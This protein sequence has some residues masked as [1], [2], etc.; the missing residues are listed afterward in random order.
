MDLDWLLCIGMESDKENRMYGGA[1]AAIASSSSI[2]INILSRVP[3]TAGIGQ[4]LT[5]AMHMYQDIEV[6]FIAPTTLPS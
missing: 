3:S 1:G 6:Y 5:W 4:D 2:S